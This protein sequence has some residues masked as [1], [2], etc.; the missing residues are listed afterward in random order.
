MIACY[1]SG[2]LASEVAIVCIVVV[3]G[4]LVTTTSGHI[5]EE[6]LN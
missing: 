2:K 1:V 5:P 3:R 6:Y 4:G